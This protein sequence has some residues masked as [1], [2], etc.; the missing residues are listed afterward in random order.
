MERNLKTGKCV[1]VF[2]D[3]GLDKED[4]AG[5]VE[6]DEESDHHQQGQQ[7]QQGGGGEEHVQSAPQNRVERGL[8]IFLAVFRLMYPL[9]RVLLGGNRRWFAILCRVGFETLIII[10]S[11]QII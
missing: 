5:A 3:A 11:A 2:A 7:Q 1:S 4:G 9:K 8:R 6:A 10:S